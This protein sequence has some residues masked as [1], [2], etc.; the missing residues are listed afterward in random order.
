MLK[1]S[2]GG[3]LALAALSSVGSIATSAYFNT[4]FIEG[5]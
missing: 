5:M 4:L 2:T 3:R 1:L